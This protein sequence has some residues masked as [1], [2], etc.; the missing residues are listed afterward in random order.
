MNNKEYLN[1]I[2]SDARGTKTPGTGLLGGLGFS[3][4]MAKLII[5]AVIASILIIVVGLI[6]GSGKDVNTDR[7]IADRLYFRTKNV[8]QV[9]DR[10]SSRIK[11]PELRSISNSFKSLI[12]ELNYH[13]SSSLKEDYGASSPEQPA[14]ESTLSSE[15]EYQEALT[16]SLE[17]ARITGTLDRAMANELAYNISMITAMVQDL[18]AQTKFDNLKSYLTTAESNLAQL[19]TQLDNYTVK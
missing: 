14:Q 7:D 11:S 3:P 15:K 18:G 9:L 1:Q 2:A 10:N 4:K 5:G 12:S 6:A 13:V 17:K 8:S 19:Q 16:A